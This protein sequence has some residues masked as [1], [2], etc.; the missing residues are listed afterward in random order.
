[1]S[2][3]PDP[4]RDLA[5]ELKAIKN[6]IR[7]LQARSPFTGSG[8][9]VTDPGQI[10]Q[11][12]SITIP[13]AGLLL[14][15]GGD[16]IM[17]NEDLVEVFRLGV[18]EHGDRGI[19]LRREDGSIAIEIRKAFGPADDAQVLRILDRSGRAISGDALLNF[20]GFDAPHVPITW[21]QSNLT[22]PLTRAQATNSTTFVP[23]FEHR[24]YRQNPSLHLQVY[25]WCSDATTAGEVQVW[26][27]L[28]GAYLGGFLGSPATVTATVPAGTTTATI[29][30]LGGLALPSQMSDDLRLEIHA[31][32]TAGTGSVSVAVAR[33]VGRGF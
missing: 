33:S 10:I 3:L 24:G 7:E 16:V 2:K 26:N 1:M 19:T 12:G 14:V 18:Q 6:D 20:S 32:R 28:A 13:G 29:Y 22:A 4:F 5:S 9:G 17:L 21:E 25:A 27:S 31:R 23:L 8:I 30:E 11:E 15:D